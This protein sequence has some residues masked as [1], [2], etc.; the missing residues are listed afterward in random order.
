MGGIY[1]VKAF[2]TV[3]QD[4]LMKI[5]SRYG[6]PDFSH[7]CYPMSL[8]ICYYFKFTWGKNKH[9]FPSFVGV[10]QGENLAPVMFLFVMQ[11][12]M[13]SLERQSGS[14]TASRPLASVGTHTAMKAPSMAPS[15]LSPPTRLALSSNSSAH[16][17]QVMAH[18]CSPA[19]T[20]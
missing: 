14:N 19:G 2:E 10:K 18:S 4:M 15:L 20:T 6:I 11:V 1:L 13:E 8:P 3:N 9:A 16:Y 7:P 12:A 17:M 5:P